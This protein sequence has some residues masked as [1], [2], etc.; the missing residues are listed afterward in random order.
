MNEA[1]RGIVA[2]E[3][4]PDAG[5]AGLLFEVGGL[6]AILLI[7]IAEAAYPNFSVHAN[8]MSDL[9]VL[10]APTFMLGEAAGLFRAVPW[11]IGAYYLFRNTGR[12]GLMALAILPGVTNLFAVLSPEDV[13]VV[14]HSLG[15][16][17]TLVTG[18]I[19]AYLSYRVVQGP[20]RYVAMALGATSF[21]SAVVQFA[22]Y[23][24]PAVHGLWTILGP[25]GWESMSIFPVLLWL[26]CFG[27]YLLTTSRFGE[28][29]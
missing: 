11:I 13:S 16:P 18:L 12:R 29:P 6:A 20:F 17:V 15:A 8:A 4:K 22:G 28:E 3:K 19:I 27:N 9:S 14:V 5:V 26:V 25:G 21:L 24:V 23:T 10:K 2:E 7:V 1:R